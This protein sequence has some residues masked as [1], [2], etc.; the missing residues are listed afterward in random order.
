MASGSTLS[1]AALGAG[2]L[3]AACGSGSSEDTSDSANSMHRVYGVGWEG[4]MQPSASSEA[5]IVEA[6]VNG[7]LCAS[8]VVLIAGMAPPSRWAQYEPPAPPDGAPQPSEWEPP[9]AGTCRAL[10]DWSD[11]IGTS[12]CATLRQT[13]PI[14]VDLQF[15]LDLSVVRNELRQGD[16][17]SLSVTDEVD[18][19]VLLQRTDVIDSAAPYYEIFAEPDVARG[20]DGQ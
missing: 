13:D 16:V 3:L 9:S 6:C 7:Q 14:N 19:R 2:W 10:Y 15:F 1:I 5:V 8:Q 12:A 17:A 4:E 18:S 20:T 11:E